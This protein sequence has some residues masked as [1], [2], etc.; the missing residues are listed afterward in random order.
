[1]ADLERSV[2]DAVPTHQEPQ[3]VFEHEDAC[4]QHVRSETTSLGELEGIADSIKHPEHVFG[5]HQ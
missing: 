1:M 5:R 4:D 2:A 3:E